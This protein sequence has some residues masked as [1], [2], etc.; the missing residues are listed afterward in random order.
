MPSKNNNPSKITGKSQKGQNLPEFTDNE[1]RAYFEG[2][3]WPN[4]PVC[5]HC[6]SMDACRLQG[7]AHRAGLLECRDCHK[8]F[9]V[10]VGS[11]M[12]DSHLPLATWAKAFHLMCSSKKGI[13]ALQIQ[14]NLGLG[15]YRTAWFLCHRIRL[16]MKCEPLAGL[17]KNEVQAD[18]TYVGGKPRQEFGKVG[19]VKAEKAPI[20]AL[21]ETGGRVRSRVVA[22][23]DANSLHAALQESVDRKA[24]IVTDEARAYIPIVAPY[25][26]GHQT[27]NHSRG[28]YVNAEGFNTNT[29]ESFF[30]L[31]KRGIY[32][33]FHHVSKKHLHRYAAEFDYRWNGRTVS[34]VE[35][36]DGAVKG[37]E[38]KRLM[39]RGP[40]EQ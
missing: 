31:M 5:P 27:V 22:N 1:A 20:V 14:R 16:A 32:G 25:F 2:I 18:E 9:S 30:A 29:A 3:R 28:Q 23:V 34:D 6:G 8:Q 39:Y 40:V 7:E 35:R 17:L 12:E 38:G 24:V 19:T 33:V 37:A 21:V 11:V 26:A 13:S 36:R 10:T 15:S 4:G